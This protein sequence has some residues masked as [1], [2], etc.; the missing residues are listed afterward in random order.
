MVLT[1]FYQ[2]CQVFASIDREAIARN[3]PS[4]TADTLIPVLLFVV[5]RTT[6]KFKHATLNYVQSFVS[7]NRSYDKGAGRDFV[8]FGQFG[9]G[10]EVDGEISDVLLRLQ[11]KQK[12]RGHPQ[13]L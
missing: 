3:M 13:V 12:E 6:L 5:C 4:L 11:E 2:N 9:H 10:I 8:L 7:A 1:S